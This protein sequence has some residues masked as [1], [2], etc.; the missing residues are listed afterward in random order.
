MPYKKRYIFYRL[1]EAAKTLVLLEGKTFESADFEFERISYHPAS[2]LVVGF[3]LSDKQADYKE[4]S[5]I[6]PFFEGTQFLALNLS[7][8][9]TRRYSSFEVSPNLNY[10]L[11]Y[12]ERGARIGHKGLKFTNVFRIS[13]DTE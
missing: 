9:K 10:M 13:T 7:V 3:V 1:D 12:G 4:F 5:K 2:S 8:M 11:E 6:L